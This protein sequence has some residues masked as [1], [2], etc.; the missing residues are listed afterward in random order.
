VVDSN[1]RTNI[2]SSI[3]KYFYGITASLNYSGFDVSLLLQGVG[4]VQV[5]NSA[6]A[7]LENFSGSN[8]FSTR[9]LEAWDGEGSTN[10]IPRLARN[11][12]NGNNRFSDRWVEDARFMRI[13][14]LQIGYSLSPETLKNLSKGFVVKMRAYVGVQNLYTFTKYL[15]YDPE[16]TRGFSF[17]KG[18][19]PLANGQDSGSS[20]QP[21]IFQFGWQITF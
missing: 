20:P 1:D 11:D 12:P 5:Y 13:K 3:P 6:R 17:Q 4:K 16:V 19:F 21:R 9:A 14:N 8:N 10:S 18:D 7:S 15:G 2:G